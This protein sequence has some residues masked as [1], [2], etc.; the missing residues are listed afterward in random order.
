MVDDFGFK[1]Y[2]T[3]AYSGEFDLGQGEKVVKIVMPHTL[4][5]TIKD[6]ELVDATYA[7]PCKKDKILIAYGDSITQGYDGQH[8]SKTYAY[9]LGQYLNAEVYNKAIGGLVFEYK[10][11]ECSL[12]KKADYVFAAL[13]IR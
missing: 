3:G 2:E 8:P 13:G 1:K 7:K 12:H 6:L 10:R 4:I 9:S 5:G 11:V